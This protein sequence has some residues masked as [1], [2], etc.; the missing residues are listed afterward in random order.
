MLSVLITIL[1]MFSL[2]TLFGYVTHRMLHRPYMGRFYRSHLIHHFK[3]YPPDDF[4]SDVYRDPG[5]DNTVITFLL[6]G[7]PL[8]ILPIV[9]WL[10]GLISLST[11]LTSIVCLAVFGLANNYLHDQMHLR[12]G[13]L[14]R[15][16]WFRTLI[17][18]HKLHHEDV[19]TNFGIYFF[20]W[21]RVFNSFISN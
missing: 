12:Q 1:V 19:N 18:L 6:L 15:F 20:G 13:W 9:V 10:F 17:R 3:L 8:V 14:Q 16:D 4:T 11:F 21:D 7:S 5:K 2:I